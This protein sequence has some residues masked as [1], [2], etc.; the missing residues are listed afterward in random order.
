MKQRALILVHAI[1][2]VVIATSFHSSTEAAAGDS[3]WSQWRGS[4]GSGVSDETRLPAEWSADKN[5]KWKTPISGRG[6]SSPIVWGNRVFLTTDIEGDVVPGATAVRH[7]ME[8]QEFKHPDSVGADRKHTLKVICLDRDSGKIVWERTAYE[9]AVYDNRH[10]KG[11]F[12]SPTPAADSSRVYAWFGS[13]GIYCYDFSG[14]QLWKGSLGPIAT[15]GMGP[16]SSPVLFENLVILQCDEDSGEK[17]LIVAL[18]RRTGKEAWR[19]PRHVQASWSTPLIVRTPRR[20]EL[21]TSGN[22]LIISYDPR[23][24]KELWRLHGHESNA[25]PSPVA[26][27]GMVFV[28]AGFPVKRTFAVKLGGSG[29][30]TNSNNVVW[31]YEKGSAYVPSP[32]LYGDYLYLM[33]DRGMLT[34]LDAE[35]GAVK[36]EGGRV[37]IPATFTASPVAFEGKILLV[38]E[39]GDTF[40]IKAGPAHELITTNSIGEPVYAS[41]AIADGMIFIRGER[42][43][44][45]I[46]NPGS[47]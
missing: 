9:G 36:Y 3:N 5:I 33:T 43:L 15:M 10:R 4:E 28:S 34:C 13:E 23:T 12:A 14:K 38:S 47:K 7:M 31:K 27:H 18:D 25:I 41:P 44:Y 2:V 21:I 39:D 16:G 17:S 42:S 11:S 40:V 20:V 22:E 8:G 45:C 1:A 30:L 26:G 35:T 37:P 32:I 46:A 24:G 6:H 19:S 29:D